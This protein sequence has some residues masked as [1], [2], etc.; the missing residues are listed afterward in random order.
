MRGNCT[1]SVIVVFVTPLNSTGGA[2]NGG[3]SGPRLT[4]ENQRST[5]VRVFAGS[6]SPATTS[7]AL[8]GP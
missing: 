7:V 2:E 6:M 5:S 4:S 3:T 1:R 8:L